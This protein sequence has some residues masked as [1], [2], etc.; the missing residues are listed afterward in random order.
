MIRFLQSVLVALYFIVCLCGK[1]LVNR[2]GSS[3]RNIIKEIFFTCQANAISSP[4][5]LPNSTSSTLSPRIRE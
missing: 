1:P 2:K 3:Y 5:D 4:K